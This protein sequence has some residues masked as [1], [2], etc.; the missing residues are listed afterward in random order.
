MTTAKR[1]MHVVN[2]KSYKSDDG[3]TLT[4]ESD[5]FTPNGNRFDDDWVYRD[6][7]GTYIDHT[8][9]RNDAAE[10]HNLTLGESASNS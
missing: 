7:Q 10:K 1:F 8:S 6:A 2:H 3:Y 5:G 9:Y 4:R